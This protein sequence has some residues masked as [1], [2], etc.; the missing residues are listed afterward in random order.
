VVDVE[1]RLT[2]DGNGSWFSHLQLPARPNAKR[3]LGGRPTKNDFAKLAPFFFGF[4][5]YLNDDE[6]RLIASS[7]LKRNVKVAVFFDS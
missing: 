7:I 3:E 5:R 2:D 4:R 1:K 6:A